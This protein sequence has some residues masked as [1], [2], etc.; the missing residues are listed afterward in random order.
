MFSVDCFEND[1]LKFAGVETKEIEPIHSSKYICKIWSF[2][3]EE[4][5]FLKLSK[6]WAHPVVKSIVENTNS[7]EAS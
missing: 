1:R 5:V 3:W 7:E 6:R 4:P 2:L